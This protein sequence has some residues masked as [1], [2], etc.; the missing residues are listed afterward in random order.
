M[1]VCTH[2]MYML[3]CTCWY[4]HV[5][6]YTSVMILRKSFQHS[7]SLF[8]SGWCY[9]HLVKE[10]LL[11]TRRNI[12]WLWCD[13][14]Y[15]Y[16]KVTKRKEKYPTWYT[17]ILHNIHISYIIYRYPM[18]LFRIS[19]VVFVI[20][21]SNAVIIRGSSPF[22]DPIDKISCLVKTLISLKIIIHGAWLMA[23]D[24]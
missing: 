13:T 18:Y 19:S 22:D 6:T 17:D 9:Y 24:R 21:F 15:N 3:I 12:F 2:Y 11:N 16:W 7:D 5:H 23:A 8:L 4:V 10:T 1:Y 14:N 20:N